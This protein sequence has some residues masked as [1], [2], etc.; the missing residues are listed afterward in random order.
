MKITV[1]FSD[2]WLAEDDGAHR[3]ASQDLISLLQSQ[4]KGAKVVASSPAQCSVILKEDVRKE[5]IEKLLQKIDGASEAH[6]YTI[7]ISEN[8]KLRSDD[9]DDLLAGLDRLL[10]DASKPKEVE[11]PSHQESTAEAPKAGAASHVGLKDE[12][13]KAGAASHVGLKDEAPEAGAASHEGLKDEASKPG[14]DSHEEPEARTPDHEEPQPESP[15]AESH[16]SE[17]RKTKTESEEHLP[18]PETAK[19]KDKAADAQE[20]P[21]KDPKAELLAETDNLVGHEEFKKLMH[22]M[23]HLAEKAVRMHNEQLLLTQAYLFFINEGEGCTTALQQF[24]ELLKDTGVLKEA[25]SEAEFTVPAPYEENLDDR[26]RSLSNSIHNAMLA[27]RVICLDIS[28]WVQRTSQP[29]FK[30]LLL[31]ISKSNKSNVIVFRAPY[32]SGNIRDELTDDIEDILS[33]EKVV[34]TPFSKEEVHELAGRRIN[35]FG[36]TLDEAAWKSFDRKMLYEQSDGFYYGIRTIQKA[37]D[38]IAR[39]A[40]MSSES[41]VIAAD[42]VNGTYRI[43]NKVSN[44]G[45]E[46]LNELIGLDSVKQMIPLIIRQIEIARARGGKVPAMHMRFVGNPGTGKTTVARIIGEIMKEKG[47]LRVGKFYEYK[48]RDLC[49]RYVGETAIKTT[50]ICQQAYGSILFIDEAYS[51]YR[52]GDNPRDY[53]QEAIDTLITEMENHANDLVVIFAGYP[54]EMD[55]LLDANPGLQSRMPYL[56]RFDNYTRKELADIFMGMAARDYRYTEDFEKAVRDYF[57]EIDDTVLESDK[58]G[59][60]RFARNLYERTWGFAALRLSDAKPEDIVLA[61][62]DFDKA[63]A[64]VGAAM[65]RKPKKMIGF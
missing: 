12:A 17:P 14:A 37:V 57:D 29:N 24:G 5:D 15:E 20:E 8:D 33:V 42:V 65:K 1:T 27:P 54:Q 23:D 60:G 6:A 18:D 4:Y 51:L 25:R 19:V 48:G 10:D 2:T 63:V 9:M 41:N 3:S 39:H 26:L 30:Q 59:N 47:L 13:P 55:T 52:G 40:M 36:Y 49:G 16:P 53:G 32:L 11:R 50:Q 35:Q 61:P 28:S 62:E 7:D 58:F 64:E 45:W 44:Q 43:R 56:V 22:G 21:D 38:E 34:F 46:E 31:E